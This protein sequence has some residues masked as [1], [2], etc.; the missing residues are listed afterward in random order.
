MTFEVK[1]KQNIA[2]LNGVLEDLCLPSLYV[3]TARPAL[4]EKNF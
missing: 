1:M 3:C 4:D 2:L